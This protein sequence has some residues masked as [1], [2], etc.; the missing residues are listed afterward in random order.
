MVLEEGA[1]MVE[2]PAGE[3]TFYLSEDEF[4]EFFQEMHHD[5][6]LSEV[7]D[8]SGS[9]SISPPWLTGLPS[10]LPVYKELKLQKQFLNCDEFSGFERCLSL[11][12]LMSQQQLAGILKNVALDVDNFDSPWN[13]LPIFYNFKDPIRFAEIRPILI[14]IIRKSL[15][16]L[17]LLCKFC[18]E[19]QKKI[20]SSQ[21]YYLIKNLFPKSAP[22][23]LNIGSVLKL[24][25][26]GNFS[27]ID[28]M[29]T[30]AVYSSLL[31][32]MND[33]R[34]PAVPQVL[35]SLMVNRDGTP[36]YGQQMR[37]LKYAFKI[38]YQ[39]GQILIPRISVMK[40]NGGLESL[41]L[42]LD[43]T[44]ALN[45]MHQKPTPKDHPFAYI[46]PPQV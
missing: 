28:R 46:K 5:Q 20:T 19:N 39:N 44:F 45:K 6:L 3:Q 16:C 34:S 26:Q 18:G 41:R 13:S 42:V 40:K 37:V 10:P 24:T 30:D 32:I 12:Y 25:L 8:A 1:P 27:V 21:I 43:S 11:M 35:E 38:P 31:G 7:R 29:Y 33:L 14:E 9:T 22:Y 36:D 15:T 17:A 23:Q 2:I 4:R